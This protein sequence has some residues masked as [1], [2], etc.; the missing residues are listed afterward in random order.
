MKKNFEKIAG[1]VICL[2]FTANIGWSFMKN[3]IDENLGKRVTIAGFAQNT[4]IGAA[5]A[6]NDGIFYI[7]NLPAWEEYFLKHANG[8]FVEGILRKY[9]GTKHKGKDS[10]GIPEGYY[11]I[12]NA[13]WLLGQ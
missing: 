4:K 7:A 3:Q 11:V 5:V 13:T 9:S 6:N 8:I 12:E 10:A 2:I 1:I